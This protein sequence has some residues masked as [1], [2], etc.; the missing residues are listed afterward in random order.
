MVES[1]SLLSP[2][3]I[4]TLSYRSV[5]SI[6]LKSGKPGNLISQNLSSVHSFLN[7]L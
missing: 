5:T 2:S 1:E 7:V 6:W 4:T 3:R